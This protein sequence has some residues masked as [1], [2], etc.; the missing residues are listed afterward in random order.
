MGEL[1]FL[2]GWGSTR[3][4]W[5]AS[6]AA[7]QSHGAAAR[8]VD[9]PGYGGCARCATTLA[10]NVERLA[11]QSPGPTAVCGWSLGAQLALGWAI[12]CPAQVTHLILA[13]ATPCFVARDDWP[14][15]QAPQ[16]FAAFEQACAAEPADTLARFA[17]LQALDDAHAAT[18]RQLLRRSM[19]SSASDALLDGLALLRTL[20]LRS[21]VTQLRCRVLLIHG[22]ND[23]VVPP[24]ASAALAALIPQAER[25]VIED[26][27]H[28]PF[29][30]REAQFAQIIMQFI[31]DG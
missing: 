26:A 21:A 7:L 6:L 24:A 16:A 15:G 27:G 4:I 31:G 10:T 5:A 17:A 1:T 8:A 18:V 30:A 29:I 2:H 3:R 28:A 12:A 22:A 23:R 20:D 11:A 13:A 14:H 9:L 25:R 19:A